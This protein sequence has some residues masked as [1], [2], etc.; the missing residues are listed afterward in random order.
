MMLCTFTEAAKFLGY[1]SRSQLYKM[2]DLG[3]LDEYLWSCTREAWE[4]SPAFR[5]NAAIPS[6]KKQISSVLI[7]IQSLGY[8]KEACLLPL[9]RLSERLEYVIELKGEQCSTRSK[10]LQW[11]EPICQTFW[12]SLFVLFPL[13]LISKESDHWF[14]L[15]VF[16]AFSSKGYGYIPR[17][18]GDIRVLH[19]EALGNLRQ[20]Q[21]S[22][23]TTYKEVLRGTHSTLRKYW[24]FF[25]SLYWCIPITTS[26]NNGSYTFL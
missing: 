10:L 21:S 17:G 24:L 12:E 6:K 14:F 23:R 3:V 15:A 4:E 19:K 11:L 22:L 1:S 18:R 26:I 9:L 20:E 25:A 7:V 16:D 2:K 8:Q 5:S 13:P